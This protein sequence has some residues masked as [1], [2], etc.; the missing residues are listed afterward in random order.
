[1][2]VKKV[3]AYIMRERA[4]KRELLVF[5][6]RDY[7]EAGLQVPAGTVHE[8]EDILVALRREIS[9]ETGLDNVGEI[10]PLGVFDYFNPETRKINE[11]HVFLV[12]APEG[13]PDEW[14]W[15]ETGGGEMAEGYVFC[16][17]WADLSGP[18]E[19]AGDQGDYLHLV[20]P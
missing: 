7:P 15:L 19:L 3:V 11:R 8:G 18:I 14:E 16:F 2:R 12:E 4:G 9:E 20:R 5:T 10:R 13:T 17:A 1:M 6:H